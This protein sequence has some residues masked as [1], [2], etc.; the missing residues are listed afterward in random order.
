[1]RRFHTC[2]DQNMIFYHVVCY[3]ALDDVKAL[4]RAIY[5]EKDFYYIAVDSQ[6]LELLDDVTAHFD[7]YRNISVAQIPRVV[8]GDLVKLLRSPRACASSSR[9]LLAIGTSISVRPA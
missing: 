8:W 6:D 7:G 1:M 2:C 3:H 9:I 4:I 5:R